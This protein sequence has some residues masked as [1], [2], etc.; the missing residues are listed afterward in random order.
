VNKAAAKELAEG[1][2]LSLKDAEAMVRYRDANG[3]FKSPDD[4]KKVPGLDAAKIAS[5]RERLEF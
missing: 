1:L 5:L 3:S 4:L 2:E